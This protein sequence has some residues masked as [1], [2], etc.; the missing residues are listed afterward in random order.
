MHEVAEFVEEDDDLAVLHQAGIARL[1]AREGADEHPFRK[2]FACDA[3]NHGRG[4]EPL[5]LAIARMHVEI[6]SPKEFA[7]VALGGVEDIEGFNRRVP[8]LGAVDSLERY[9]EEVRGGRK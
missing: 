3:W 5:V 4:G 1:S 7:L 9:V 6:D 2:L 8:D